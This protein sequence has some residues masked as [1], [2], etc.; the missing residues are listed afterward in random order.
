MHLKYFL[1]SGRSERKAE[2]V[3][4]R[5]NGKHRAR[6]QMNTSPN[7]AYT[8]CGLGRVL[9]PP[10]AS[11]FTSVKT[12]WGTGEASAPQS[13]FGSPRWAAG[14]LRHG[15]PQPRAR[16][17]EPPSS[18]LRAA[19][20]TRGWG[21]VGQP[22]QALPSR[23]SISEGGVGRPTGEQTDSGCRQEPICWQRR[24]PSPQLPPAPLAPLQATAAGLGSTQLL[25]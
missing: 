1:Q 23:R 15:R 10:Q 5:G 9:S 25:R 3:L 19:P 14:V 11:D 7:G 13:T 17:P 16:A 18:R 4:R 2:R 20:C 8:L 24:K 6:G 22:L 21:G 12:G